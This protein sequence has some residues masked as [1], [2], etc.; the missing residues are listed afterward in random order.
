MNRILTFP[1]LGERAMKAN[2]AI[3]LALACCAGAGPRL[4]AQTA[5]APGQQ[6]Q[7][8]AAQ[9]PA[10]SQSQEEANPFP[11]DTSTVPVLPSKNTPD[12]FSNDSGASSRITLPDDDLDPV[13]SPDEGQPAAASGSGQGFSS[14]T[15]GIDALLPPPGADIPEK[16]RKHG[17][18][19]SLDGMPKETA[20]DD[21]NVGNYYLDN[22]D[23]KAAYSRFQ[24]ALV[25]APQNPDVYWGL[26]ESARHLGKFAEARN[27]Y[28]QVMVYDPDSHRSK[29]AK[30]ALRDPEIANAK[31]AAQAAR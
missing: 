30:K 9:K 10:S 6:K 4:W 22:K 27:Y 7:P 12:L 29:E 13:R 24:S 28:I 31:P 1:D 14:S 5:P 20:K 25:L 23:W 15:S 21:I 19:D 16:G 17:Q 11:T 26:A 8:A 2:L 3:V 18:G